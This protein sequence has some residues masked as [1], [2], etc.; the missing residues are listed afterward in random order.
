MQLDEVPFGPRPM[1]E[2]ERQQGSVQHRSYR[3]AA[4]TLVLVMRQGTCIGALNMYPRMRP[5]DF[6]I[7]CIIQGLRRVDDRGQLHGTL[8]NPA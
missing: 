6:Y 1:T 2:S 8:R 5:C 3:A 7:W 4:G